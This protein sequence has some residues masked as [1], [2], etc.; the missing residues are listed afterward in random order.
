M[1]ILNTARVRVCAWRLILQVRPELQTASCLEKSCL[2]SSILCFLRVGFLISSVYGDT[3]NTQMQEQKSIRFPRRFGPGGDSPKQR[4]PTQPYNGRYCSLV[5]YQGPQIQH[6]WMCSKTELWNHMDPSGCV[7]KTPCLNCSSFERRFLT[8]MAWTPSR[9][10]VMESVLTFLRMRS[11]CMLGG[12]V[13]A[14][15]GVSKHGGF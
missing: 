4:V 7:L 10:S 14:D 13:V 8:T 5:S 2:V 6:A 1:F 9:R 12:G 15:T 11:R 3:S